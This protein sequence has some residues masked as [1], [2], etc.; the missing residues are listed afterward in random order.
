MLRGISSGG[1]FMSRWMLSFSLLALVLA[2]CDDDRQNGQVTSYQST[3]EKKPM[4]SIVPVIDN[5][6]NNYEWSLSDEFSSELY[7]RLSR[8][9]H[10]NLSD[11]KKVYEK[12]RRLKESQS[13]FSSDISWVQNAF[14]GDEF[15]VF[16]ELVEHEE[17]F[18]QDPKKSFAL[19]ECSA[20][21]NITMR[22]R[23]FDLRGGQ[24]KIVLQEL[25][26]DTSFVPRQFTSE[27]LYQVCWGNVS[28]SISPVGLAH[29]KFSKELTSRIEDYILISVQN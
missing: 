28:Y 8:R 27:N 10:L 17:L 13:P 5:T 21:L 7:D 15:V 24:P 1:V 4:V 11:A 9:N 19:A 22:V 2:G 16:L 23:I 3:S 29:A 14:Q 18:R 26:H 20:N 12:A 6:K 25:L